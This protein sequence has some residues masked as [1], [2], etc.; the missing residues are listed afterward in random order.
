NIATTRYDESVGEQRRAAL[1]RGRV[2][3]DRER[4]APGRLPRRELAAAEERERHRVGAE[5]EVGVVGR[6]LARQDVTRLARDRH[7]LVDDEQ[8]P[9]LADDVERA[10]RGAEL[11]VAAHTTRISAV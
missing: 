8:R 1:G 10:G 3:L 7:D 11:L 5:N 2:A 6:A 9:A 4:A